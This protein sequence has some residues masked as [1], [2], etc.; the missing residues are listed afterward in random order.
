MYE[1]FFGFK[2]SPFRI[3]PDPRYAFLTLSA[4]EA[5]AGMTYGIQ[6][7]KGI[8][9]LAGEAGTGKTTLLNMLMKWLH[10][11]R[12]ATAF[13]F[14]TQL[15][16]NDLF[17]YV[18]ADFGIH[19]ESRSKA[20]MLMKLNRWLLDRHHAGELAVLVVDE[21]QNLTPQ[22]L[23]EIRLLT[24]LET[25]TEKLL[26]IVLSGQ[27]ELE[28]KLRHPQ[29]R[30]L[31][32]RITLCCRTGRLSLEETCGYIAQRLR[33]AGA[34]GRT[35]FTSEAIARLHK[36]ACGIPRVINV[37][38]DHALINGFVDDRKFVTPQ[39]VDEVAREFELSAGA[40]DD[41]GANSVSL[42]NTSENDAV[43]QDFARRQD[44]I[45]QRATVFVEPKERML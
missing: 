16:V 34:D 20:D 1:K 29:L 42:D 44:R 40:P 22:L 9:L 39:M 13:V 10:H 25:S 36:Y 12:A 23:E 26:Q 28:M 30:Q 18:M 5:L 19:S 2:E 7:R 32:Q 4:R 45:R 31:R 35:I 11:Q 38:C 43:L 6:T 14:N 21:A 3:N 33:I 15:N 24:N 27:P 37:L 41:P 8:I 17:E